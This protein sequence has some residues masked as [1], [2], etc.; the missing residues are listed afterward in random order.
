M[1]ASFEYKPSFLNIP[2]LAFHQQIHLH[3]IVNR[4]VGVSSNQN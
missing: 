1:P 2:L 3:L 4:I